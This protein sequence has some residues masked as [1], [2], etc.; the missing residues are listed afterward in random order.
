MGAVLDLNDTSDFQGVRR[1]GAGSRDRGGD[2]CLT[3]WIMIVLD[4]DAVGQGW[5]R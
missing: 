5:K 2:A 1:T 3:A 4:Q